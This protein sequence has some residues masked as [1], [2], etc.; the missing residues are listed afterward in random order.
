MTE[1]QVG[2]TKMEFTHCLSGGKIIVNTI[3]KLIPSNITEHYCNAYCII[4]FF[5]S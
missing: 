2:K 4:R 1:T 5:L 3:V